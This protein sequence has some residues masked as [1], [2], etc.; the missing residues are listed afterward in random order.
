VSPDIL[1]FTEQHAEAITETLFGAF[2]E[3]A[4]SKMALV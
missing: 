1:A 3:S 4:A 2:T